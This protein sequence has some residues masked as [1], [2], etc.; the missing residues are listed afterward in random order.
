VTTARTP[1][2]TPEPSL[3]VAIGPNATPILAP[4]DPNPTVTPDTDPSPSPDPGDD[5]EGDGTVGMRV[6]DTGRTDGLL[7]SIVGGVTGLF[8]G[9]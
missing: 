2:P 5:T 8:F 6:V 9:G 3:D 4:D 1:A 7:Q